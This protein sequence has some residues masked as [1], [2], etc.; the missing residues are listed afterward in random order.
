MTR[1]AVRPC[2]QAGEVDMIISEESRRYIDNKE[3]IGEYIIY[4]DMK[5]ER[6]ATSRNSVKSF[7]A[8]T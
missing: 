5:A 1:L 3:N 6:Y 8:T 4:K 7:S 2:D